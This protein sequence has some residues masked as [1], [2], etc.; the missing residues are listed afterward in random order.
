[1]AQQISE[2]QWLPNK[3]KTWIYFYF[4]TFP[5]FVIKEREKGF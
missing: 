2:R 1:M 5:L 4:E 3:N